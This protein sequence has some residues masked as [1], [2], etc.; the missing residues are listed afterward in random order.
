MGGPGGGE[1]VDEEAAGEAEE[2]GRDGEVEAHF[3][4]VGVGVGCGLGAREGV[5]E[6]VVLPE[7]GEEADDFADQ[8]GRLDEGGCWG[9]EVVEWWVD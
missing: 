1:G 5:V 7:T 8:E 6:D 4:E 2:G 9:G 3:G